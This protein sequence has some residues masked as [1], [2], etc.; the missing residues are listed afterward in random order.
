MP[1]E[2][3]DVIDMALATKAGQLK[4]VITDSGETSDPAQRFA[5]YCRKLQAYAEYVASPQFA[6]ERPGILKQNVSIE[7]MCAQP[8][9]PEMSDFRSIVLPGEPE[10]DLPISHRIFPGA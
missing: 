8:P 4:L 7:L 9:T 3:L 5:L 2:E 1:L 10:I 6:K